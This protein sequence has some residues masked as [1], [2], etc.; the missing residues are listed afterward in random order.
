MPEKKENTADKTWNEWSMKVLEELTT[1]TNRTEQLG[2]DIDNKYELLRSGLD[3]RIIHMVKKMDSINELLT[4]NGNP[5]RGLIIRVD[6]LEQNESRRVWVLRATVTACVGAI[7]AT[8]INW[9]RG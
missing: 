1:L 2:K 3:Q 8:I 4:G 6:R 5:E 7:V 9:V